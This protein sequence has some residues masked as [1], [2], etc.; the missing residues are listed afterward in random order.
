MTA[1]EAKPMTTAELLLEFDRRKA[2]SGQVE[3][4]MSELGGCR[5]RAGYRLNQVPPDNPGGS[6]QAAMGSAIHDAVDRV[7]EQLA[8]EGVL[9]GVL[10]NREVR[11]A[12]LVGHFDRF[13]A[14]QVIDTK[15]TSGR[16]LEHLQLHGPDE[17]HIWQVTLYGCA[18]VKE[19]H[20]VTGIGIDYLARDTGEE[21]PWRGPFRPDLHARAALLWLKAVRETP[22]EMLPRDYMPD[23]KMCHGCKWAGQC[24]PYG[25]EGKGPAKVLLSELE[26]A[27]RAADELWQARAD[28]ASAKDREARARL[29]LEALRPLQGVGL[30]DAGEHR[31]RFGLQQRG[32]KAVETLRFAPREGSGRQPA[33]GY[34]EGDG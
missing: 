4:G 2:R 22:L 18:L 19:G 27:D 5:R 9:G 11:Y 8:D 7:M 14:G 15:T 1:T 21:W 12:G 26:G 23:S 32:G 24:W 34:E 3:F 17:D 30:V 33:V 16:W 29:A 28:I 13:D 10:L 20:T 25:L 31:L 6:V